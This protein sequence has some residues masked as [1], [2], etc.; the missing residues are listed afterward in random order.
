MALLFSLKSSTH[1]TLQGE[2][3]RTMGSTYVESGR[4]L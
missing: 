2:V 3:K 4:E 1:L